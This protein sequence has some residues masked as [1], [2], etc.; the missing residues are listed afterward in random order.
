[1]RSREE[2]LQEHM[3]ALKAATS[4]EDLAK[5]SSITGPPCTTEGWRKRKVV[6]SFICDVPDWNPYVKVALFK[7][8]DKV[9]TYPYVIPSYA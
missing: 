2:R 5:P 6:T 3:E 7:R 4:F 1:M 8:S 9:R